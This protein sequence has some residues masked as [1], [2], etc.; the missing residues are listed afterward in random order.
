MKP[1]KL[2]LDLRQEEEHYKDFDFDRYERVKKIADH[3]NKLEAQVFILQK[4]LTSSLQ[5]QAGQGTEWVEETDEEIIK[6]VDEQCKDF[7]KALEF[8]K[9]KK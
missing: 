5:I 7:D 3:I 6:S 4:S 8:L 9:G 1:S 2:L